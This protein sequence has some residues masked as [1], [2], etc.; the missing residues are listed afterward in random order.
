VVES[1]FIDDEHD[2]LGKNHR[3]ENTMRNNNNTSSEQFPNLMKTTRE[4][5]E[6]T[7]AKR[8]RTKRQT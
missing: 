6:N 8:K 1:S 7:L 2:L 5:M 3:P 4:T